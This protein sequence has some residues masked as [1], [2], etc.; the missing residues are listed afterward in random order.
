MS[1]ILFIPDEIYGTH[2]AHSVACPACLNLPLYLV[3]AQPLSGEMRRNADV[4]H[5]LHA[6]WVTSRLVY[7]ITW[8]KFVDFSAL[9]AIQLQR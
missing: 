2:A 5:M 9:L 6:N 4:A 7:T 1:N 3:A 8:H